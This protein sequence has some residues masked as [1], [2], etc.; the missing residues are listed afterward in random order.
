MTAVSGGLF[1]S[2]LCPVLLATY[3]SG[4]R[5]C[6]VAIWSTDGF[7][8]GCVRVTGQFRIHY[9]KRINM[10]VEQ[11]SRDLLCSTSSLKVSPHWVLHEHKQE[12]VVRSLSHRYCTVC[13]SR[14]SCDASNLHRQQTHTMKLNALLS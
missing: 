13:K 1:E 5:H 10:Y 9:G 11:N 6:S 12:N 4:E 8:Q 3:R 14:A 7:L 2:S